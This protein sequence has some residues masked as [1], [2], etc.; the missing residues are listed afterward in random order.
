MPGCLGVVGKCLLVFWV[1][2]SLT[3][4][5]QAPYSDSFSRPDLIVSASLKPTL[6][7]LS[8]SL[9]NILICTASR[10]ISLLSAMHLA[11]L[12]CKYFTVCGLQSSVS[13][14]VPR[15]FSINSCPALQR[16]VI[17]LAMQLSNSSG[18]QQPSVHQNVPLTINF[19][20]SVL[21]TFAL[22]CRFQQL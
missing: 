4:A 7:Q 8:N 9:T 2:D 3:H 13:S 17:Q 1:H 15:E 22:L 6:V 21:M 18:F 16:L 14:D 10:T 12:M 20:K 5:L 19:S 11:S